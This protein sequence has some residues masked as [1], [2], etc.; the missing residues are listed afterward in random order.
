MGTAVRDELDWALISVVGA[1]QDSIPSRGADKG[2]GR[3]NV[4]ITYRVYADGAAMFAGGVTFGDYERTVG[5]KAGNIGT[6]AL[7]HAQT[8]T[9][10]V[11]QSFKNGTENFS[12]TADGSAEFAGSITG[13]D[14]DSSGGTGTGYFLG[15]T[16]GVYVRRDSTASA[17]ATL[18]GGWKGIK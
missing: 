4:A 6:L 12:V 16:G 11:L 1:D 13:A 17:N 15:S 8:G 10:K 5:V 18:I 2:A 7:K 9:T 3:L 14:W